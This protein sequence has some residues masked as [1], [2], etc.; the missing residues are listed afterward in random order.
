MSVLTP[1]NDSRVGVALCPGCWCWWIPLPLLVFRRLDIHL[2][3]KVDD[4]GLDRFVSLLVV[5]LLDG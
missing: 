2:A 4:A 5:S 3:E 1:N